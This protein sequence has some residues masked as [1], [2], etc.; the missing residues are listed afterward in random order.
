MIAG[1]VVM[2]H[3]NAWQDVN[4]PWMDGPTLADL[5]PIDHNGPTAPH[6]RMAADTVYNF[7]MVSG[8]SE[9]HTNVWNGGIQNMPLQSESWTSA[10]TL[11]INGSIVKAFAPVYARWRLR[12]ARRPPTRNW[13]FDPKLEAL[14]NQPPGAPRFDIQAVRTW[15]R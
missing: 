7:C 6:S 8:Q 12:G 2:L 3:S 4:S 15:R 10:R 1:D 13:S 9:N 5:G 11:E 14:D